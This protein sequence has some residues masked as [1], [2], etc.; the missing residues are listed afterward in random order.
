MKNNTKRFVAGERLP[1]NEY[2]AL[3]EREVEGLGWD[4]IL[5]YDRL[6]TNVILLQEYIQR[7]SADS[8]FPPANFD[9]STTAGVIERVI[10]YRFDKPRLSFANANL[11]SSRLDLIMKVVGG[12][13]L[14]I[15]NP[16]NKKLRQLTR[17]K[18][19]DSLNGPVLRARVSLEEVNIGVSEGRVGIDLSAG[20]AYELSFS[21]TSEE[22]ALAGASVKEVFESW[23]GE[24]KIFELSQMPR[25]DNLMKPEFISIRTQAS[26]D[27]NV[28][29]ADSEG[30]GAVLVFV[31]ME[32][33]DSQ[34]K[35][36]SNGFSYFIPGSQDEFSA[37]MLFSKLKMF[38]R[39]VPVL[40]ENMKDEGISFAATYLGGVITATEGGR[41]QNPGNV[42]VPGYTLETTPIGA[43]YSDQ[44]IRNGHF[45]ELTLR[46]IDGAIQ[47]RWKGDGASSASFRNPEGVVV[48]RGEFVFD[49]EYSCAYDLLPDAN[50]VI[51]FK[52]KDKRYS[53]TLQPRG[54]NDMARAQ[55]ALDKSGYKALLDNERMPEL[56]KGFG[57]LD[58]QIDLFLLH[59]LLFQGNQ[60]FSSE[61]VHV[62]GPLVILGQLSPELTTFQI[63]PV[64]TIVGAGRK[65][66]FKTTGANVSVTWS[67]DNLPDGSGD[68][69]QIDSETG[70][71][72]A[73]ERANLPDN[74]KRVIV[75][76]TAKTGGAVSRALVGIVSR[77][78]GLDP[79][80]LMPKLGAVSYKVRATSLDAS[81][82]FTFRMSNGALGQLIDDPDS[83]PDFTYSKLYVSPAIRADFAPG[84]QPIPA[85]WLAYRK[86]PA[87]TLE[88]ELS[89]YL[90]V[91][92]V[93]AEGSKGSKQE[94]EVLLPLL[95]IT[96]W[97]E[98]KPSGQGIQLEH[99]TTNKVLGDHIVPKDKTFWFKVKGSG[100]LVDGVYT[101]D[102]SS[103]ETYAVIVA[104][105]AN[106]DLYKW[107]P[108][109]L[110]IPFVGVE[111]YL[112]MVKEDLK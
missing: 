92:Q 85:H 50:G 101:P 70:E 46:L 31:A 82:T 8:W 65:F 16:N 88:E 83:D 84:P 112:D 7:F 29:G 32:G 13:Q 42:D 74:H 100:T 72:T 69:G 94:V 103:D 109:I 1:V 102:P 53:S 57:D 54:W 68:A 61:S 81:E 62:P 33:S 86:T 48:D 78:I 87:W 35:F 30:D 96:N 71:Y 21:D 75:T 19:A 14:T 23:L 73:P 66:T 2:L 9:V 58:M 56:S 28:L 108:A 37:V 111:T 20:T 15:E 45:G 77:D 44:R 12:K 99:W 95:N 76:A 60:R 64:E 63:D 47:L 80:V 5:V 26:A 104:I 52:A 105:E 40:I 34:P 107:V 17:I 93:L 97:F 49:Y 55:S 36:P 27:S 6:K 4:A 10:D 38:N 39:V 24:K 59:G 25:T 79:I 43:V 98:F 11:E 18:M 22:G 3:M 51:A 91:E 67:V 90:H 41:L 106:D 89:Q 110:P